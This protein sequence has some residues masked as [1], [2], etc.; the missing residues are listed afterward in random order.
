[1]DIVIA[2]V[3]ITLVIVLL[4]WLVMQPQKKVLRVSV[5]FFVAGFVLIYAIYLVA[6]LRP[7]EP[8]LSAAIAFKAFV[9]SYQSVASGADYAL[10]SQSD[11]LAP[12]V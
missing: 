8:Q 10:L 12:I 2:V 11:V 3:T 4:A 9:A 1:M 7:D 6:L 5:P